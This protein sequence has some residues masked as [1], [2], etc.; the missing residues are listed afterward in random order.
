M[1]Q[2][3]FVELF[4]CFLIQVKKKN[5]LIIGEAWLMLSIWCNLVTVK[6]YGSLL[7]N[8]C[9]LEMSIERCRHGI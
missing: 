4:L 1:N 7:K 8:S 5:Y 6:F 9:V 2:M 3:K